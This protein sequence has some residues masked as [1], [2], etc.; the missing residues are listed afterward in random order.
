[1]LGSRRQAGYNSV[2]DFKI[3]EHVNL[4]ELTTFKIGG[5]ARYFT[6]IT[7]PLQIP[8]IFAW[9]REKNLP[10]FILSGGSNT[11]FDDG[12]FPGLVIKISIMSVT[13]LAQTD[14]D[15]K[16]KVGAGE[17]W[18]KLVAN[19]VAQGYAGLE[20]LSGIPGQA[21]TAPVQNI[22]AYGQE[23]KNVIEQV[24]AFDTQALALVEL[25][26]DDCQ[27]SYRNSIFKSSQKGRYIITAVIFNLSKTLPQMPQ[28]KD[29]IEYFGK[30]NMSN[31]SLRQI[32][33]AVLEIRK[34]KFANPAEIPNAGSFFKN[35]IIDAEQA[36]Q[37]HAKFDDIKMFEMPDGTYKVF[38]GWLI[39]QAGLKGKQLNRVQV[40]PNHALVL[41]NTGGASQ[42]DL[43][44]LVTTI[45]DAVKTKFGIQLD[46]EPEIVK[47]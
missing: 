28:Y 15:V 46:P 10:Y 4:G 11:I 17:N 20:A 32:R 41:E 7:D 47:F 12:E 2:M 23:V 5:T 36:K 35:P 45:Q 3:Q 43:K 37:L 31:P 13:V 21:G 19:M 34:N 8:Q 33:D 1:M 22:G 30:H 24:E 6:E 38:A 18:D 14:T 42:K 39:E 25:S 9:L 29:V 16:V 44:E 27:F 40:D 26:N